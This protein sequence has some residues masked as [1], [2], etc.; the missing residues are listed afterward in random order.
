MWA[1]LQ[2]IDRRQERVFKAN[3]ESQNESSRIAFQVLTDDLTLRRMQ[4]AQRW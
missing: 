4:N 1:C 2:R 3:S